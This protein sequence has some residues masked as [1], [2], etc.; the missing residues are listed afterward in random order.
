ML[1]SDRF[2]WFLRIRQR[3]LPFSVVRF[4]EMIVHLFEERFL[5]CVVCHFAFL[6]MEHQVSFVFELRLT[7]AAS[8]YHGHYISQSNWLGFYVCSIITIIPSCSIFVFVFLCFVFGANNIPRW[9]T[10]IMC[11]LLVCCWRFLLLLIPY[12]I[13]STF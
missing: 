3:D 11:F 8:I 1:L 6:F 12:L 9:I 13:P 5:Y 4:I 10:F 2:S 7:V